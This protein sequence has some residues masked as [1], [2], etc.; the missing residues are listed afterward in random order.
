MEYW[1]FDLCR[2]VIKCLVMLTKMEWN[3]IWPPFPLFQLF[4][5]QWCHNIHTAWNIIFSHFYVFTVLNHVVYFNCLWLLFV[6]ECT[7]IYGVK[8]DFLGGLCFHKGP[9]KEFLICTKSYLFCTSF[10]DTNIIASFAK[11]APRISF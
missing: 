1:C 4:K 7:M 8:W 10:Y 6:W 2:G 9:K 11:L 5:S 3:V